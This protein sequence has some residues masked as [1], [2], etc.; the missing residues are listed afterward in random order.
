MESVV[1]RLRELPESEQDEMAQRILADLE[2][3]ERWEEK[4]A[5]SQDTLSHL[6]AKARA[7]IQAGR[8]R[9]LGIDQL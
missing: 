1:L 9:S 7:D 5:T 8:V 2:D 4:F 6:A 3:E